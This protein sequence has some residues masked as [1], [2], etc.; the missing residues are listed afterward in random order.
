M[1]RKLKKLNEFCDQP[2]KLLIRIVIIK[3]LV[4]LLIKMI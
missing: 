2:I 4:D 1:K 3:F